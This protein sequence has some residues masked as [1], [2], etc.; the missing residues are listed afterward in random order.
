MLGV[1]N[2]QTGIWFPP[3]HQVG[4]DLRVHALCCAVCTAAAVTVAMVVVHRWSCSR[5]CSQSHCWQS[6][7]SVPCCTT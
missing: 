1:S 5:L 7:L 2:L 3:C 4:W 6:S